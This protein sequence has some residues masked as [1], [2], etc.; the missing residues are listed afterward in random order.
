MKQNKFLKPIYLLFTLLLLS[1]VISNTQAQKIKWNK[2]KVLIYTKNG[3]GYVHDNIAASVVAIQA[4]GKQHGFGVDVSD[5][6]L[7]FTDENLKQYDAL[8]FSN[9]NNDVFDTDAQRV[10]LMRYIQAGGNFVGLHSA[11]GT[12]RKW[13]WFKDMLGGTFFWHEPGQSFTV[14][15]LD[16][17]NPSL[18]HLPAKWE[19]KTDEFYFVKEMGV[20]LT[21][22]AVNDHST[23]Q[24]PAGKALDTFGTVFP[25]VWWHE[26]DGGRAFYTSL[27]HQKEDYEQEDLRKHILGAIEWAIGPQKARNYGKAYATSPTDEVRK[28]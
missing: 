12:E 5:D 2:V 24:K 9:T 1:S 25:S 21:V 26:Y 3:K 15:V 20:N 22:L 6:P 11:S 10:A 8:I 17:K 13:R 14:N 18:A 19:R 7:T 23:I 28:K 16:S 27:G 4:L